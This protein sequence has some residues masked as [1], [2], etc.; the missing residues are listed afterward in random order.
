MTPAPAR[1]GRRIGRGPERGW[2]TMA[3]NGRWKGDTA[4]VLALAA[5]RTARAAARDA[6]LGE[7]T[8]TRRL[9]DSDFRRRVFELRAEM[10]RRALGKLAEGM[11]E[12]AD[13]LRRLLRAESESVRL[14]AA[15]SILEL[16]DRLWEGVEV[17]E[18]LRAVE[19]RLAADGEGTR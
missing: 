8:V 18:R 13:T 6:G 5:G 19:E 11:A 7:R 4:L 1:T 12:A 16:G 9:A 10:V 15:R 17:A 14:G 2:P 3:E